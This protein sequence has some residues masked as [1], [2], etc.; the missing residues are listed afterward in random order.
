MSIRERSNCPIVFTVHSIDKAEY[1]VGKFFN[2]WEV[3]EQAIHEA[4][5]IIAISES[6]KEM[7]AE[8]YPHA[9][10]KVS[11]AGNGIEDF[12]KAQ[13]SSIKRKWKETDLTI[14]YTGRF[15][16]YSIHFLKQDLYWQAAMVAALK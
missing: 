2:H 15:Q 6:E 4:D 13:Q 10:H 11:V 14:L 8:Y 9:I 12:K 7:L 3:Q 16:L 1:E 5:H